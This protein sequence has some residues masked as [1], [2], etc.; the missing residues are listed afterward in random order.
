MLENICSSVL[1]SLLQVVLGILNNKVIAYFV[2]G[3]IEQYQRQKNCS[4]EI[5]S[6]HK[7]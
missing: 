3:Y 4:M 6:E 5:V 7:M 1:S 2:Q